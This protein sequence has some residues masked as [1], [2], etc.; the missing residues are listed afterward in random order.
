MAAFSASRLVCS[1]TLLI[2]LSTVPIFWISALRLSM[3]ELAEDA[4]SANC[5]IR[6][7]LWRTTTWPLST[8]SSAVCAAWAASSAL[9]ATSCTVAVIWFIAVATCSVSS[10]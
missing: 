2:T 7:M 4:E 10:F 9:R 3:L 8:L 6:A 1:A 5:S